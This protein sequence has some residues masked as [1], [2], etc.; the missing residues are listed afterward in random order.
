ML[1]FGLNRNKLSWIFFS[2]CKKWL[3]N[4]DQINLSSRAWFARRTCYFFFTD[5]IFSWNQFTKSFVKLISRKK[6]ARNLA[7]VF[8]RRRCVEKRCID[9][10][11]IFEKMGEWVNNNSVVLTWYFWR[12]K[13]LQFDLISSISA[14]TV[15]APVQYD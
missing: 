6:N 10:S 8:L 14:N 11:I 5:I 4:T 15:F 3:K 2:F 9:T 13:L 12:K 7:H 1:K